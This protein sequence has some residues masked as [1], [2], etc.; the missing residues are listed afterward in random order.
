MEWEKK[1]DNLY[2]LTNNEGN[3]EGHL[4]YSKKNKMLEG[5]WKEK[6]MEGM[7]KIDLKARNKI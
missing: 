2:Y 3:G 6:N 1:E 7:W 4:F 5:S